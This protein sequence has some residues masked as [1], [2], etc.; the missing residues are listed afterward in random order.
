MLQKIVSGG[1][2]GV[3]M[4]ALVA[5][6]EVGLQT[7]GWVPADFKNEEGTIQQGLGL[8]PTPED[9]STYAR[10][11]P[12]SLRTE[13]NVRD[14]DA[15]LIIRLDSE[16]GT[17]NCKGTLFTE[18]AAAIYARPSLAILLPDQQQT[19]DV[20]TWLDIHDV[21]ILNVAGPSE[22]AQPGIQQAAYDF[23]QKL[24]NEVIKRR[25]A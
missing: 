23:L 25:S 15:T 6:W 13:W 17:D 5:A 4:A 24:F 16:E 7:G 21:R 3:D 2:T 12:R 22:G 11:L 18:K 9:R 1:Q 14:S 10:D 19:V 20:L 8:N